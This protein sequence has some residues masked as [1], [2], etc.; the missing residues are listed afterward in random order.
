MDVPPVLELQPG[1][2]KAVHVRVKR[3]NF[4]GP[5]AV[6]F[7]GLPQGIRIREVTITSDK[8]EAETEAA[9]DRKAGE[10]TKEIQVIGTGGQA[11]V[12]AKLELKVMS[13]SA[14]IGPRPE[15]KVEAKTEPRPE[16]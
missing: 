10:G 11:K 16:L 6:T 7:E 9:A 12:V 3:Q 14:K 5:V 1:D 8:S 15:M 13:L 2:T 4:N